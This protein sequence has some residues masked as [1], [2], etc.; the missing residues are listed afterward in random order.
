M[1]AH[2]R[3]AVVMIALFTLLTGVLYPLAVT[4][5]AGIA[6]PRQAQGSLVKSV[7]G[8]VMG[9]ALIAQ[10]FAKPQ[11]LHPRASSAGN[12]YDATNSSGSN[13]GPMDQKL[14]D[15]VAS[16]ATA[17]RKENPLGGAVPV[18]AATQSGS[19]LDPDISP[20]NARFQAVRIAQARG[21]TV[22]QVQD[23]IAR[24][25]QGPALGFIGAA[26]V[27]VLAVNLDLDSHYPAGR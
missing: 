23:V 10:G 16:D 20:A 6:F 14:I 26:H 4:G 5:I 12:G 2:L 25:V 15:R 1:F 27:N 19:G 11:Y 3:P 24:H 13:L 22:A 21:V 7:N 9:S 8:T 17:L 18:D